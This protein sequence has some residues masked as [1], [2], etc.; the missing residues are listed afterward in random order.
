MIDIVCNIDEN[1][2]EHCGVMLSSL[3]V[4]NYQEK[5]RIHIIN[6]NV[7]PRQKER[8][9]TFCKSFNADLFFYDVDFASIQN[10]PIRAQDHLSL[11]AYLRLFMSSLLPDS[12]NKVLYLDC[13]LLVIDSIKELWETDLENFAVAAVEERP[14]FDTKSPATLG[15]PTQYSYFNSGVM[16]VNL[17]TWRTDNLFERFKSF[18]SNNHDIIKLHDQ[19]VLNA[20][21]YEKRK[22]IPIRWNIMDFFLFTQPKIQE[23]RLDDLKAAIENPAIIHFT[24]KRKPWAHN[25]DSPYRKRYIALAHQFGWKVITPKE[26]LRYHI[27]KIWYTTLIGIHLKKRRTVAIKN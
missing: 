8:L 15:Y 20:L 23:R 10:F 7:N 6:S 4:H 22:F 1:Y 24:G 12:I 2:V 11:A 25:C 17:K 9:A 27:R 19:D 21:L 3:F 5:F 16:L 26:S 14:P 13:D 18:I